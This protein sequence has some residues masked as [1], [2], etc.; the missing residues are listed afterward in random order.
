MF[1][2]ICLPSVPWTV[3][4]IDFILAQKGVRYTEMCDWEG[5]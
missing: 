2:T 3:S 4:Y 5:Q 1:K